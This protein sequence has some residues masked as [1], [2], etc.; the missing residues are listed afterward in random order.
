MRTKNSGKSSVRVRKNDLYLQLQQGH[1]SCQFTTCSKV[2]ARHNN[3]MLRISC[4]D[5]Q[6]YAPALLRI[7]LLQSP[8][9]FAAVVRIP[10]HDAIYR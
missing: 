7:R 5:A 3:D 6:E 4:V 2:R 1:G 10:V 8:G 9:I